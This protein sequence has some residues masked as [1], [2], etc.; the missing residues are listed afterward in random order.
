MTSGKQEEI[1]EALRNRM[2]IIGGGNG[3][4]HDSEEVLDTQLHASTVL[5]CYDV[6]RSQHYRPVLGA[7]NRP[8]IVSK[9][10]SA[11]CHERHLAENLTR[12]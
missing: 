5:T 1:V 4:V 9:E 10:L 6:T 2:Y 7:D 8:W 11:C 3:C 12:P